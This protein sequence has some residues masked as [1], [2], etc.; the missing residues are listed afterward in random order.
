MAA[1]SY[2]G[3]IEPF[4]RRDLKILGISSYEYLLSKTTELR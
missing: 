3:G 4:T 2:Y 1:N